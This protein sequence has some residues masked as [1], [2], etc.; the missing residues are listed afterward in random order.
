MAPLVSCDRAL[1]FGTIFANIPD[2]A[3][4]VFDRLQFIARLDL[5]TDLAD[6]PAVR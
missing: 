1:G 5:A 2:L 4:F 6:V 3:G